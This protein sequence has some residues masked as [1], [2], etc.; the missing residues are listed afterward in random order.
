M[1]NKNCKIPSKRSSEI[2]LEIAQDQNLEGNL[3]YRYIL[4]ALGKRAFGIVF[5]FFSLPSVLP[6]S[7]IPGV[8]LLFS[9]PIAIFALEMIFA[10]KSLW[11]PEGIANKT[12]SHSKISRIITA[13][14]PYVMK[15][16]RLSKP[17]WAL[18]TCRIM[19]IVNGIAIL[20]L[21]FLL[22]LPIPLSNSI[23]GALLVIFSLGIAEKDGLL[24]FIGY[25]C[26]ILYLCFV[27]LTIIK[28]VEYFFSF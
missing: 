17:R 10:R 20:C 15:L 7:A 18:M 1:F 23:F 19:E 2:L 25:F 21:A 8:S 5:L 16:E 6:F 22:M 12:I 3:T 28:A 13:V 26:F 24:I 14:I 11:L 9:I 27:Y 4:Q